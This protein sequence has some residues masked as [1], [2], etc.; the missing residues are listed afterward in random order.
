M[1]R[2]QK[3]LILLLLLIAFAATVNVS[4]Q[5]AIDLDKLSADQEF[6]WGVNA[7]HRGLFNES[8]RAFEKALSYKPEEYT[9][10]AMA[11]L[12][13]MVPFRFYG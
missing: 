13:L 12:S 6:K 1:N 7:Y 3:V 2:K 10:P 11:C 4:A 9:N 5:D 8:A